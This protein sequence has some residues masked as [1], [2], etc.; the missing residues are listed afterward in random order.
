[1]TSYFMEFRNKEIINVTNGVKIGYVDDIIFDTEK[2]EVVSIVV[3]GRYRFFGIFG[4]D[5][6]MMIKWDDIEIIGEDTILIKNE[7]EYQ[8]RKP[9]KVGFF[10]KLFT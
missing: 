1:M 10:T 4:R 5:E 7:G 3:Y 6:D 2:A 8:K 9:P